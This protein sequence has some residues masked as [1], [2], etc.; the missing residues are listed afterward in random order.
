MKK[1]YD[2]YECRWPS[3]EIVLYHDGIKV[4][5][6]RKSLLELGKYLEEL[7]AE[8]YTRGYTEEDVEKARKKWKRIYENR[9]ERNGW[10][11]INNA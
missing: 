4:G 11:E 7:E 6:E 10:K 3:Y 1:Q 9:I 5:V 8:G 2:Y